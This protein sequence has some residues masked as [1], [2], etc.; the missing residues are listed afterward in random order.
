M[1]V[2]DNPANAAIGDDLPA[3]VR[4]TD[5]GNWNRFAAVN[6]EFVPIHMDD[7][8][9][10]AAGYPGAFGMG[11]L[12]WS[13][14]HCLLRDWLGDDGRIVSLSCKFRVPNTRGATVTAGG[15]VVDRRSLDGT[16][17]L[18]LEVWTAS[19]DGTTLAPGRATVA[20]KT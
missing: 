15:R 10:R 16:T 19:S 18:D 11:N 13:Y 17:Y 4:T 1:T 14:L 20:L 3:F 5:L 2:N 6:D 12:Q 9:A 8:A 7:E